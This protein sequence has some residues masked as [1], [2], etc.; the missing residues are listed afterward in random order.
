MDN[1]EFLGGWLIV[2]LFKGKIYLYSN[3]VCLVKYKKNL[4]IEV[5]RFWNIFLYGSF[6]E[7]N[8]KIV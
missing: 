4:L 3:G 5:Y 7:F 2:F 6:K 8:N 1:F